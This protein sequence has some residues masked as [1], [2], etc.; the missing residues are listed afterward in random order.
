MYFAGCSG[1][2]VGAGDEESGV[3]EDE[4]IDDGEGESSRK[5]LGMLVR[6]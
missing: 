3:G 6:M 5:R 1:E 2:P 4:E